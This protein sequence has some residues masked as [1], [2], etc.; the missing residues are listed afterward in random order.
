M[1]IFIMMKRTV[2]KNV[3]FLNI[4]FTKEMRFYQLRKKLGTSRTYFF[5]KTPGIFSFFTLATAKNS[6]QTKT[7]PLRNSTNLWYNTPQKFQDLKSRPLEIPHDFFL[8][9]PG[10]WTLFLINSENSNC[11]F[12]KIV[13]S[14]TL[15]VSFFYGIAQ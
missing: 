5:E 14:S 4:M 15:S 12:F 7:S 3:N 2:L 6:R 13:I 8:N 11:Y 10:N 1:K 9:N